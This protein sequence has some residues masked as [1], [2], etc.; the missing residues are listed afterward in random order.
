MKIFLLGALSIFFVG[1][2]QASGTQDSVP[3]KK[4]RKH[5]L[6]IYT[7]PVFDGASLA[8]EVKLNKRLRLNLYGLKRVSD[9]S[10]YYGTKANENLLEL[11]L[12]IYLSKNEQKKFQ[13][14][15]APC[16]GFRNIVYDET[17]NFGFG[18]R[19]AF[20]PDFFFFPL[21]PDQRARAQYVVP[22]L[23]GFDIK[24]RRGFIF[25]Y[26][27]GISYQQSQGNT[28]VRGPVTMP[29]MEGLNLRSRMMF[30]YQF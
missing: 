27:S 24:S 7:M 5:P 3:E 23:I 19:T 14:F 17:F 25:E 29:Y 9:N 6:A 13:M 4:W 2:S 22:A 21:R 11:C 30:G 8:A 10:L 15:F 18:S 1:F 16:I 20:G 12:K 28:F 26:A